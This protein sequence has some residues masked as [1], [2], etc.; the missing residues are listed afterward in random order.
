MTGG[1]RGTEHQ[2]T[3]GR[4]GAARITVSR[5]IITPRLATGP[6]RGGLRG[7]TWFRGHVIDGQPG[8]GDGS[9]YGAD[10]DAQGP[11]GLAA[12]PDEEHDGG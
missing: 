6:C 11:G 1:R 7:R 5:A 10:A 9:D 8:R 12:A 4:R 2:M 3:H